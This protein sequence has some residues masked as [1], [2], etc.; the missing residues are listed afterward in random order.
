MIIAMEHR[1]EA[2]FPSENCPR[3]IIFIGQLFSSDN[4]FLGQLFSSD[5]YFPYVMDAL[6]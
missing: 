1:A 6:D 3:T 2:R 5:S 4:Y